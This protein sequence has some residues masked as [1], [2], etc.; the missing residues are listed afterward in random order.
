MTREH[1]IDRR[2]AELLAQALNKELWQML[3]STA[4]A[5]AEDEIGPPPYKP[6]GW[7]RVNLDVHAEIDGVPVDDL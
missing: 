7:N 2:A 3:L 1:R 4:R 6:Y 5:Q